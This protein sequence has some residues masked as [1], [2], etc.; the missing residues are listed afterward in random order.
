MTD[1][2]KAA[3]PRSARSGS[4]KRERLVTAA[5]EVFH[6]QGVERSTLSDIARVADVPVGNVYYYFKTKEQ[7]VAAVVAGHADRLRELTAVLDELATPAERLKAL[8]GGW[9]GQR[10][11]AAHYGCPFGTLAGELDRR[12]DGHDRTA[13]PV[14]ELLLDWVEEQFR[15]M[16]HR[17]EARD[18]AVSLVSAYQGMSL[19]TNTLH[20]PDLMSRQGRRLEQW[21]DSLA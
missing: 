9:V 16:G 14:M 12:D 1:S 20:D 13:A 5:T 11:L 6:R 18:L 4:G 8:V 15:A 2:K 17:D 19:L 21:I 7:L 3:G 10:D